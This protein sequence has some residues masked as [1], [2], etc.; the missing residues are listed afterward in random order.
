MSVSL[1]RLPVLLCVASHHTLLLC[2]YRKGETTASQPSLYSKEE[3]A[4]LR[5]ESR[6]IGGGT[7]SYDTVSDSAKVEMEAVTPMEVDTDSIETYAEADTQNDGSTPN[8]DVDIPDEFQIRRARNK[9]EQA[10]AHLTGDYVPLAKTN[11]PSRY[12]CHHSLVRS[13]KRDMY[14]II[15]NEREVVLK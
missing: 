7:T 14:T 13:D 12:A 8:C 9:R 10:R 11:D 4:R 3:L 1:D 15:F 5:S 2:L 6:L